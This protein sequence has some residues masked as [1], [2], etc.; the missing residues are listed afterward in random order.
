MCP[1]A[2]T[3]KTRKIELHLA[4]ARNRERLTSIQRDQHHAISIF[5]GKGKRREM[6]GRTAESLKTK[7]VEA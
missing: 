2:L 6:I 3:P 5:S 1:I 7:L 4:E